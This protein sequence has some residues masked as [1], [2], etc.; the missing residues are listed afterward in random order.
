MR[1][2]AARLLGLLSATALLLSLGGVH[3]VLSFTTRRRVREIGIRMALGA[4]PGRILGWALRQ[5]AL[6]TLCGVAVGLL[7]SSFATRFLAELLFSVSP[8]D[9]FVFIAAPLLLFVSSMAASYLAVRHALRVDPAT[10]F[11]SD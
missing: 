9:P 3:A 10:A 11:R 8:R 4:A 7:V 1:I 2:S 6:L 5:G